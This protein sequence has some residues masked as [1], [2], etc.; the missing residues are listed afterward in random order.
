MLQGRWAMPHPGHF[1]ERAH[2]ERR[3]SVGFT[4]LRTPDYPAHS[5]S[6]YR[7]CYLSPLCDMKNNKINLMKCMKIMECCVN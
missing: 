3:K 4:R 7:L 1:K 5:E 6:F 2:L